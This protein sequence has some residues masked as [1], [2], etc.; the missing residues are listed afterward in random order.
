MR[1]VATIN[2][3]RMLAISCLCNVAV[4]AQP[5]ARERRYDQG[6]LTIG[7]FAGS[8]KQESNAQSNTATRVSYRY[9]YTLRQVGRQF[10]AKVT[11][12]DLFVVFLP[13]E[14]WWVPH[15]DIALL[16]HEQGHFDIAEINVRKTQL[17]LAIARA[18]GKTITIS[19]NSKKEAIALVTSKLDEIRGLIDQQ[20][21]RDNLEYDRETRHGLRASEQHE[22]R[23]IQQ[24][25]LDRLAEELETLNPS[26]KSR[27]SRVA[28]APK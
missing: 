17:A 24:L 25:T 1:Q 28:V 10:V 8:V 16:D 7:E 4:S 14:S 27:R 6:P 5:V 23:R 13:N 26:S 2:V 12:I 20:I 11:S 15:S 3:C 19:T 9:R 22:I 18:E 21:S